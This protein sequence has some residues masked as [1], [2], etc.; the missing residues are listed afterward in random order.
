MWPQWREARPPPTGGTGAA[1]FVARAGARRALACSRHFWQETQSS[2]VETLW[3][4]DLNC[5]LSD[6]HEAC[7]SRKS[8]PIW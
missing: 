3:K 8:R 2:T 5:F 1:N 4:T 7:C 6:H